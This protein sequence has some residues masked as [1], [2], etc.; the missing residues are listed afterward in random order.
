MLEVTGNEECLFSS[1]SSDYILALNEICGFEDGN[2]A[3]F[4]SVEFALFKI[5]SLPFVLSA[6]NEAIETAIQESNNFTPYSITQK[7]VDIYPELIATSQSHSLGESLV[8]E[9]EIY[10]QYSTF[11]S[12]TLPQS[13][14]QDRD[15]KTEYPNNVMTVSCNKG[16]PYGGIPRIIILFVN[17]MS[18]KYRSREIELGKS[19]KHFVENLGYAASYIQGGMNE[20]VLIQLEKLF[21]TTYV[22][23]RTLK[24]IE[25]DGSVTIEKEDIRFHLFDAKVT[26]EN[27]KDNLTTNSS[28]RVILSEQYF[29]QILKHPVP[30]SLDAIRMLKKS[31]LA[32]DLYAYISYRANTN[33]LVPAKLSDLQKQFAFDGPTWKFKDNLK[34]AYGYV[35]KAWPEC[36]V[37]IKKDV[38]LIHKMGTHISQK[39]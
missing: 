37:Q 28:A 13:E 25:S 20:Q 16:L 5:K 8:E 19:I 38:M 18:V 1:K 9:S 7:F 31:P 12:H 27:I 6:V 21:N 11:C 14:T 26:W 4:G 17:S 15:L 36:N 2:Q 3:S 32:L 39:P 34:R 10:Y 23:T 33:R 24:N 35:K 29:E 22:H 30:L